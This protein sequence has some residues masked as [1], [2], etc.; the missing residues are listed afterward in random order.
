VRTHRDARTSQLPHEKNT[1]REAY[2]A[3]Q[4]EGGLADYQRYQIAHEDCGFELTPHERWVR[5]EHVFFRRNSVA[6][7]PPPRARGGGWSPPVRG[8]QRWEP[9]APVQEA[10]EMLGRSFA[11]L[12]PE[13][14]SGAAHAND[15]A[16]ST[17][18]ERVPLDERELR[19]P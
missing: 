17:D 14:E 19:E 16:E 2:G 3:T 1:R 18:D 11:T 12:P 9:R 10:D 13:T 15:G 6:Q 7:P 8:T 5:N 4:H